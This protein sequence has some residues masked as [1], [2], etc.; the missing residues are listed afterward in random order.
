MRLS[1]D[2]SPTI[3][4]LSVTTNELLLTDEHDTHTQISETYLLRKR[5]REHQPKS[6]MII[7][8]WDTMLSVSASLHNMT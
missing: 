6:N 2:I 3:F 1:D 5:D 4:H 7:L 8:I